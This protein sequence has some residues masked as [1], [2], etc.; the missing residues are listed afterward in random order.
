MFFWAIGLSRRLFDEM[1][2]LI[3]LLV[4]F[5]VLVCVLMVLVVLMQRPR[6]EGLGAAFGGGVAENLFGAHTSHVLQKFTVWLGVGFFAVT[7]LL[8]ILYAKSSAGATRVQKELLSEPS[9]PLP[10]ATDRADPS[11]QVQG[12]VVEE[13]AD[14]VT[15]AAPAESHSELGEPSVENADDTEPSSATGDGQSLT[16]GEGGS[17]APSLFPTPVPVR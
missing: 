3:P 14:P 12:A 8:A 17:Q 2:V 15:E 5:H 11:R 7:L 9:P 4:V 6:S 10:A 1:S 16:P 13:G